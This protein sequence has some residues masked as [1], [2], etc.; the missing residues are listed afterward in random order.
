MG[1]L[2]CCTAM[3]WS[4]RPPR[5]TYDGT[6]MARLTGHHSMITSLAWSPTGTRLAS[7]GKGRAEGELFIWDVQGWERV[8]TRTGHSGVVYALAWGVS[9]AVLVSGGGDGKLRWWDVQSG[10]CLWV[11]DAHQGAVQSLGRSP[12]GRT[13]ASCGDDGAIR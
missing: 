4:R 7:G 2:D 12:D 8:D 13:L 1:S 10:A 3:R 6:L 9:E 11:C 5:N